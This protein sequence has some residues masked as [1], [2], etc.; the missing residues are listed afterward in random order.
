MGFGLGDIRELLAFL[1]TLPIHELIRMGK[2]LEETNR[3]LTE[4]NQRLH[5]LENGE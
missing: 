4:L 1:K 5:K 2:T 3:Q